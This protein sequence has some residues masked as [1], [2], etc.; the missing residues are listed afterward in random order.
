[1]NVTIYGK[2]A[3]AFCKRAKDLCEAKGIEHNYIDFVETGMT[4]ADLEAIVGKPVNTVPQI[5]VD[6]VHIGGYVDLAGLLA[7]QEV[8]AKAAE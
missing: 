2:E 8:A 7:K 4:K 5:F 6:G 3:C 1:M